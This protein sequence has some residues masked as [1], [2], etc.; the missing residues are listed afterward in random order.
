M[1]VFLSCAYS[2]SRFVSQV[3]KLNGIPPLVGLLRS[4]SSQVHHT[5]S[6]ALRNLSFKSDDNKEDIQRCG[7][8]TEAVALLRDTDSTE[9]QKQLT[10]TS[11][12]WNM[13]PHTYKMCTESHLCVVKHNPIYILLSITK[14]FLSAVIQQSVI[15]IW[16][17]MLKSLCYCS[18]DKAKYWFRWKCAECLN[19]SCIWT[20]QICGK[21][22][23]S[24]VSRPTLNN[25]NM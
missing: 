18:I 2:W 24:F 17:I 12:L 3:L 7:G 8:I 25:S 15:S 14:L 19:Y 6:A 1:I 20:L 9:I 21:S 23:F 5:A 4:P 22:H 13:Q 10:G 11:Q 16:S